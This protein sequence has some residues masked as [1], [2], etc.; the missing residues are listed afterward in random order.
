MAIE[1]SF[2][3]DAPVED[4]FAWYSRPGAFRRL[5]AP[6]Q[7]VVVDSE[8]ASLRD[9]TAKLSLPGGLTWVAKHDAAAF[10]DGHRFV[11]ES[12]SDGPRSVPAG[13]VHWR[14]THDFEPVGPDRTRISDRIETPVPAHLIASMLDYRYHQ[15]ADDLAAH[16]RAAEAGMGPL[17]VAV[18][19]SS[20]L[21]GSALTAFLSTGGHRVIRLVRG[22]PEGP[23]ERRWDPERPAPGMLEGCDAVVHLA[24]ATI[25]GRFTPEHKQLIRESRVEPTR[26]LS[27]A[28]AAAGVG[29]FVSASA[30]GVYGADRGEEL[31]TETAGGPAEADFLADVVADWEEA[32]RA[33]ARAEDGMRVVSIRTGIVQ[34]PAGGSL[35]MLKRLFSAGLG[36]RL[37]HGRQWMSWIGLDDL[38]DVYHRALWDADLTGPVN[39]VAPGAVRN[40][41]YTR[42]LGH[43]LRRPALVPVPRLGP[44][45][46][47]GGEGADELALACQH[48]SPLKLREAG[49]HFR[50]P[51][52]EPALRHVL[53]RPAD[54]GDD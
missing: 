26:R 5:A 39:A 41:E 52:L 40:T 21:V 46:I 10:V 32:A 24:G 1:R 34:S 25:A 23:D 50:H 35:A 7:P 17:T 18:T 11:D 43:V 33:G 51:D 22:E 19:G 38:V 3:V 48:V 54:E 27:E 29:T 42:V 6:W 53:G 31:L 45:L 30:I 44:A 13:R 12:V 36:G 9:G 37:G 4:V 47:L 14:H 20:G 49:H 15:I 8:S 16:R 28:A 2:I